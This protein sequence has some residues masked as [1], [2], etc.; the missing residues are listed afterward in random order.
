[1]TKQDAQQRIEKLKKVIS[2]HRYLYHVL[3][4]QEISPEALDSLKHELYQ[5]E[6]Q[7]PEFITIDSPTQRVAG[8]P[9]GG[10]KK[11]EHAIPMLSI[12][13]IFS[14]KE[15]RDWENYLEKL[16]PNQTFEYFCEPKI[17]GFAI[18]LIYKNGVF[19]TGSTRGD[20]KIGEE[21]TQNLRTIESIPLRLRNPKYE[22]R[23]TKQILNNKFKIL[24]SFEFRASNFEFPPAELEV[25]GEVYM[26]KKD[27]EDFN[28]K[29]GGKYANPRNLAAG[30]IRQLN[31][32]IAASR[33]LKFLAY[34]LITNLGQKK[35][36]EEHQILKELGFKTD[37]GKVCNNISGIVY[38]WQ[39]IAKKRNALLYQ[40]DGTVV[41]VND[42]AL[43]ERLGVIGKSP[44]G[45]RAFKFSPEQAT[46]KVLDIKVQVG[47]TGTLTPVAV[48][49]PVGVGGVT[50]SRATLHNE[51]EIKRLGIKI[52]DTVIVGRAGDVIPDIIKVL[53]ELR[54]GKEMVFVMPRVCPVCGSKVVRKP[55]E[56]RHMCTNTGCFA[57]QR[58]NFYHFVSRPA[59][60]IKGLGPKIIDRLIDEGLVSSPADLFKLEEGDIMPLERF[61]EKSAGNLVESIQNSKNK[62]TLSRFIFALGIH[63]VGEETALDLAQY[64]RDINKLKIASKEGLKQIP[65]IGNVVAKNIYS[66]FRLKKNQKLVDDLVEVG[67]RIAEVELPRTRGSSTSA[68][69]GKTFVVTGSL[70]S[71]SRQ[72][73][74]D[75]I[76]MLGGH[77]IS[78]VSKKTD[79]L[80]VG[81]EP[82]SKLEKAKKLG[83]KIMGEGEFLELLY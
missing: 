74:H 37:L 8:K 51:D 41:S 71:M 26:E 73:A 79:Y 65:D 57:I 9:L 42:N 32:K 64:F 10:F 13:D 20:G 2:H 81:T 29:L 17:D 35:H 25:R 47:R 68:I 6:Q 11:V 44:R 27:F 18:S 70:E 78:A 45:I 15:L 52:G 7:Y 28:K 36:S 77:P 54:T 80:V 53:P 59:F 72:E 34:D 38:Y 67:V 22:I 83:I 31:P 75:K 60:D 61:A 43:F 49:E 5:L 40:I 21:V 58:E 12:E 50:V 82:G 39:E 30:S 56:A 63:H 23:N 69:Y 33:P 1:M 14:E 46:T 48:L 4:R 55:G 62:V 19:I 76:R 24:N 16:F 66:W 3:D